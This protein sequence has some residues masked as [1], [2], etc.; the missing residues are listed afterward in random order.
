MIAVTADM[1]GSRQLADRAWAQSALDAAVARVEHDLP[2]AIRPLRP[3][4]GDEQQ[5]VYPT[6]AAALRSLLLLRLAL[7]DGVDCRFGIG[8]GE[9]GDVP[10]AAAATGIPDGPGWWAARAAIDRVHALARR[11]IPGLR[12]GVVAHQSAPDAAHEAARLANAYLLT[13]DQ[14][15]SDMTERA[16]RLCYGR[17]LGRTQRALA[18][19]ET[20]TQSAVSQA[21]AASGAAAIVEGFRLLG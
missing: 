2:L 12:T 20:I 18:A 4:V 13:R 10:S 17:C 9:I 21:L 1:V 6:L 15:V 16:R 14:L 11:A 3:T 8:I 5:G 19:S 7:P